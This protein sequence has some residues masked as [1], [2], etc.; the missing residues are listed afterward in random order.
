[1]GIGKAVMAFLLIAILATSMVLGFSILSKNAPVND[2]Y[3]DTNNSAVGTAGLANT[4]AGTTTNLMIPIILIS[5]ILL[6]GAFILIF[7][8]SV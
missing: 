6:F 2:Y 8:K 4:I 3:N 1:M 5:A 7:K